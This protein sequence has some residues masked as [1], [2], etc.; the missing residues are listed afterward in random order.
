VD[1]Q[2]AYEKSLKGGNESAIARAAEA[3]EDAKETVNGLYSSVRGLFSKK[4][5]QAVESALNYELDPVTGEW[6]AKG[7]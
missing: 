2:R 7:R 1:A 5:Q 3:F 6:V 4:E